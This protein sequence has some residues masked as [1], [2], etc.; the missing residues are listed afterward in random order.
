[1]TANV[2]RRSTSVDCEQYPGKVSS[3][4]VYVVK[5]SR[6]QTHHDVGVYRLHVSDKHLR[7]GG[8]GTRLVVKVMRFLGIALSVAKRFNGM[9]STEDT[10]NAKAGLG[11]L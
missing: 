5:W 10:P 9:T 1:M 3:H 2:E 8:L 4:P 7:H 6:T 11:R